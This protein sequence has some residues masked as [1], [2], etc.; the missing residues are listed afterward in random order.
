M[1]QVLSLQRLCP[2]VRAYVASADALQRRAPSE[3]VLRRWSRMTAKQQIRTLE[4][5]V[6]GKPRGA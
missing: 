4:A 3:V 5:F 1:T 2:E 6:Q